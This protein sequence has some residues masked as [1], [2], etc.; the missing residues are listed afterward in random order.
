MNRVRLKRGLPIGA[1]TSQPLGNFASSPVDHYMKEQVRCKCYL[2]YCDDVLGLART[3]GEAWAQLNE[4]YR[5]SCEYGF[6]MKADAI[7]ALGDTLAT[8]RWEFWERNGTFS[9]ADLD[10][11]EE[12]KKLFYSVEEYPPID[13]EYESSCIYHS[14]DVPEKVFTHLDQLIPCRENAFLFRKQP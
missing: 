11:D 14:Y 2:R 5:K 10:V 1:N 12:R 9:R 3:K 6:V 13:W 8:I 7:V 4:Y